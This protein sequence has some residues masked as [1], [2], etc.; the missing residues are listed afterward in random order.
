L[1]VYEGK[2]AK[3]NKYKGPENP[4][5]THMEKVLKVKELNEINMK[6]NM[7]Q[8]VCQ[9]YGKDRITGFIIDGDISIDLKSDS[10]TSQVPGIVFD[11][12]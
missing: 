2:M 4:G 6:S 12:P 5:L 3:G 7:D 8:V 9:T 1:A 11:N 10:S